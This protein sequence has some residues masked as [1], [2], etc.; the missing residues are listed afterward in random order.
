M[1]KLFLIPVLLLVAAGLVMTACNNGG[2]GGSNN[3][4]SNNNNSGDKTKMPETSGSLT[5]TGLEN[6]NGKYISCED[7]NSGWVACN[8]VTNTPYAGDYTMTVYKT[9]I[10]DNKAVLKVWKV[11][12]NYKDGYKFE[13]FTENYPEEG[14]TI[15]YMK[16]EIYSTE[17][18]YG[19]TVV[20][21]GRFS[22][23]PEF[24]NG[25]GTANFVVDE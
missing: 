21:S 11:I 17:R 9:K 18:G 22:P 5:I 16:A 10:S 15:V 23:T 12:G 6:Y 1:K 8:S 24:V 14:H 3:N 13:N 7:I 4:N 2:G 19:D 25:I 20:A